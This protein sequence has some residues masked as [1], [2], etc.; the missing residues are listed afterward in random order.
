MKSKFDFHGSLSRLW[1]KGL[2]TIVLVGLLL[3]VVVVVYTGFHPELFYFPDTQRYVR[4]AENIVKGHGPIESDDVLAG[5]DPLYPYI[6]AHLAA[7]TPS[8]SDSAWNSGLAVNLFCGFFSI[9]LLGDTANR[10]FGKRVALI[11]CA[12]LAFD[13]IILFF[14]GLVLTEVIYIMLMLCGFN[15]LVRFRRRNDLHTVVWAGVSLGLAALT[16]SSSILMSIM[17][18][19]FI[20]HFVKREVEGTNRKRILAT[21][22]FLLTIATIL[23]PTVVRNYRLFGR[24]VPVRTGVGASMMEALGPWA[25]GGPGMD[26]IVYPEFPAGANEYDRDR[27]CRQ[28]AL[29]WVKANP[30]ETVRL[31]WA[32]L[33]RTWSVTMN[34]TGFSSLKYDLVCWLTVAPVFVLAIGGLWLLRQR[35]WDIALLIAPAAYFTLLHVVFVG[36]VRYRLPAMPFLFV[37][38]AVALSRIRFPSARTR[39]A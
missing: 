33:K 3:R 30:G 37:L 15:A 39:A 10:L 13:P 6:L 25:D 11:A 9:F 19:P 36:S 4:V 8:V 2:G 21:A 7:L 20:W 12:I 34:A 1:Y 29:A 32:K 38:A 14:H 35:P 22:F 31:A 17:L 5:T 26:R 27:L 23:T 24:F 28:A 16:R 18:L